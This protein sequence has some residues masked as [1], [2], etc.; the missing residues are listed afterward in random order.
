MTEYEI[1]PAPQK[2]DTINMVLKDPT[3]PHPLKLSLQM[4]DEVYEKVNSLPEGQS[5][6]ELLF[7][8]VWNVLTNSAVSM[9]GGNRG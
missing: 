1:I 7:S 6:N 5:R 3:Y 9:I 8:V 4:T 2:L